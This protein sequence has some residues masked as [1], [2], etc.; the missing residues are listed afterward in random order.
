VTALKKIIG[1]IFFAMV[2]CVSVYAKS[3]KD[4]SGRIF[5]NYKQDYQKLNADISPKTEFDFSNSVPVYIYDDD[6]KS[7]LQTFGSKISEKYS[8]ITESERWMIE[9]GKTSEGSWK[10]GMLSTFPVF[11][12]QNG[13]EID[14]NFTMDWFIQK[15]KETVDCEIDDIKLVYYDHVYFVYFKSNSTEYTIPYATRPDLSKVENGKLYDANEAIN[16]VIASR[17]VFTVP[18][19]EDPTTYGGGVVCVA[20]EPDEKAQPQ[21]NYTPLLIAVLV[22][23]SIAVLMYVKG[24]KE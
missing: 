1:F 10:E 5:D 19:G 3:D 12:D 11:S 18:E 13:K 23:L 16:T 6:L 22:L 24:K 9:Y 7:D 17:G 15:V 14:M 20:Q 21:E 8:I 2:L 4:I